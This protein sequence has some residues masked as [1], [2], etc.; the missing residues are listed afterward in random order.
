[1]PLGVV[2]ETPRDADRSRVSPNE[3][4]FSSVLDW[5]E[6]FKGQVGHFT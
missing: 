2:R 4:P 6:D 3:S 5:Q 1:M